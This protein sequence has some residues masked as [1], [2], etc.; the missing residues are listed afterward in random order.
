MDSVNLE[1]LGASQRWIEAG[2]R[3]LLVTV[4][5][6]WGSSPRPEGSMLAVC[7]D[8]AVA[9]SVSGG[10]IEDDRAELD[11]SI[12]RAV[13][14]PQLLRPACHGLAAVAP[15]LDEDQVELVAI[16]AVAQNAAQS[17]RHFQL[18]ANVCD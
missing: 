3:V 18:P 13:D 4:V 10:C 9:G 1:V 15:L 8:G 5:K 12:L 6:T 2:H 14:P 11:G 7:D 16:V 17:A